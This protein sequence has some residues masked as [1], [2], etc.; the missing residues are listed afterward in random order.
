MTQNPEAI[1]LAYL[2]AISA[3]ELDRLE[4]LVAPQ[5]QFTAPAMTMTGRDSLIAALQRLSAV[6]VRNDVKRVWC[7]PRSVRALG[8][9]FQVD[10][11]VP[12]EMTEQ[13]E[14]LAGCLEH[15]GL[16]PEGSRA[17]AAV[18]RER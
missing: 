9:A 11:L 6:H 16:G 14:H 15:H 2:D 13:R 1:A 17:S 7:P 8:M 18:E 12:V 10:D 3:K 5:V 4:T